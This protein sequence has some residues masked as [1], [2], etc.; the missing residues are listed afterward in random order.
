GGDSE[1]HLIEGLAT[2]LYL[3]P[4]RLVPVALAASQWPDLIHD[5][6]DKALATDAPGEHDG[7]FVLPM[8]QGDPPAGLSGREEAVVARLMQGP[9]QLS[10]AVR[11]RLEYPALMRLVSQGHVMISGVTASDASHVLGK[12]DSW[13][14]AA[15]LKAMTVFARRRNGRGDRITAGPEVLARAIIDQLKFQTVDC[16]LEAAFDEDRRDWRGESPET[17]AR[18]PLM[19]AAL[20][21]HKDVVQMSAT[22]GVPVI[23][24]GASAPSYYGAVGERLGVRMI[25]PEHAGV[26]NAIGAVVGQIAMH[27]EGSVTSPGP[28]RYVVHLPTGPENFPDRATALSTLQTALTEEASDKARRAGVE[29][30]RLTSEQNLSEVDIE[31]Q[32][33]F[34][35][36]RLKVTAHGRPRIARD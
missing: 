11:T 19:L 17:L 21:G 8:W 32:P 10:D 28:G 3:G 30:I 24:L 9:L 22:L 35:E 1:V 31:G 14:G 26:A 23:G 27:A 34:I 15:A 5:A 33:M 13:D 7:R 12:L 18:H 25:L 6:L 29:E 16:L 36:A 20:D 2:S 4:R